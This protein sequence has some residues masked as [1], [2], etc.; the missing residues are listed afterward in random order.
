MTEENSSSSARK[1]SPSS[2]VYS[3]ESE[4]DLNEGS[5]TELGAIE[6]A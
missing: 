2:S 6:P 3:C 4:E 5:A 1:Q